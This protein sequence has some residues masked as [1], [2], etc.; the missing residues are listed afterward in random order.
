VAFHKLE[1][2]PVGLVDLGAVPSSETVFTAR[3]RVQF[4][5]PSDALRR[6]YLPEIARSTGLAA[7][8]AA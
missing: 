4:R 3:N 7:M 5:F 8:V 6:P 1:S 2:L